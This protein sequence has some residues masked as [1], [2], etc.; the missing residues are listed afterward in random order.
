MGEEK[1]AGCIQAVS[2]P[3]S[4]GELM[5]DRLFFSSTNNYEKNEQNQN[6]RKIIKI[7]VEKTH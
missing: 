6:Q 2:S 5:G 1:T 7:S 3:Q 4:I